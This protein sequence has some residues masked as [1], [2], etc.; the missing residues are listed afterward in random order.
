MNLKRY[1]DIRSKVIGAGHGEDISW[2]ESVDAPTIPYDFFR[3]YA[4]VI[5]NSGMKNTIARKIFDKVMKAVVA[6]VPVFDVFRHPGKAEALDR[7]WETRGRLFREYLAAKDK[8]EYLAGL[9]WIGDITKYHLAKNLGKDVCKPDRH[10]VRIAEHY[11]TTPEE[12]CLQL[13]EASG[14]RVGTV[15]VV[16]WRAAAIGIID[17][18]NLTEA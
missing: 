6:G 3:E 15:D 13:S 5:C 4:F 11:E 17:S 2:S 18:K 12:L 1:L 7:V 16:L 10:L 14:D 9:P 8:V